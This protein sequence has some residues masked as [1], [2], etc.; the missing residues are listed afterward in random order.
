MSVFERSEQQFSISI[1]R[2]SEAWQTKSW[3]WS[4]NFA[5]FVILSRQEAEQMTGTSSNNS[6]HRREMLHIVSKNQLKLVEEPSRAALAVPPPGFSLLF[7]SRFLAWNLHQNE[8]LDILNYFKWAAHCE[9]TLAPVFVTSWSQKASKNYNVIPQL[10]HSYPSYVLMGIFSS[11]EISQHLLPPP[12]T[13]SEVIVRQQPLA[14][15]DLR[16]PRIMPWPPLLFPWLVIW[17]LN[18]PK[19]VWLWSLPAWRYSWCR[20]C[21]DFL[22]SSCIDAVDINTPSL[23]DLF[24]R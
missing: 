3:I 17:S 14:Q 23:K 19:L 24:R 8:L 4:D 6:W 21:Q 16:G 7:R 20:A 11:E 15:F 5:G 1:A 13:R 10:E 2:K 9:L 22:S 18:S 12:R